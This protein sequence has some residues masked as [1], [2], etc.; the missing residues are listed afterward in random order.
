MVAIE[1][2]TTLVRIM[3]EFF[4]SSIQTLN[5]QRYKIK[6]ITA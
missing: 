5:A 4:G 3:K 1:I 6:G 2:N